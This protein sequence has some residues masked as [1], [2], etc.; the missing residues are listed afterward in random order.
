M[1]WYHFSLH[2]SCT[3]FSYSTLQIEVSFWQPLPSVYTAFLSCPPSFFVYS[4]SSQLSFLYLW[5]LCTRPLPI[6][7]WFTP[8]FEMGGW[9]AGKVCVSEQSSSEAVNPPLACWAAG[10]AS[11]GAA[12]TGQQEDLIL[13]PLSLV[14]PRCLH[15][16]EWTAGAKREKDP[17]EAALSLTGYTGA[18]WKQQCVSWLHHCPSPRLSLLAVFS[19]R[20]GQES[21]NRCSPL[22]SPSTSQ[23]NLPTEFIYKSTIL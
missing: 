11:G 20:A 16:C 19:S 12:W 3:C 5:P 18:V 15:V 17:G 23:T 10:G 1:L 4:L 6:I 21:I 8:S 7:F 22:P 13:L 14:L 9:E 2:V